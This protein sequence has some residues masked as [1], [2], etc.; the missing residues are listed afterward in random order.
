MI[1]Y[2]T[3][4]KVLNKCKFPI[5]LYSAILL[6]F[7]GINMSSNDNTM[8]FTAE[9]PNIAVINNDKEEGITK[10]F[11]EYLHEN[12]NIKDIKN[13]EQEIK[14]ALFYREIQYIVYI[15]EGF[16][17]SFLDGKNPQL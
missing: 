2:K 3:F 15:P 5:I 13:D 7:A 12:T 4:L 9:K 10:S 8:D 14:D 17:D 1:V 11:L 16:S 6:F